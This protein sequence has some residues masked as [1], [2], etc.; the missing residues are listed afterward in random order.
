MGAD[1]CV[2]IARICACFMKKSK[3]GVDKVETEWYTTQALGRAGGAKRFEKNFFWKSWK[4][5]LTNAKRCDILIKLLPETERRRAPCKLNNEASQNSIAKEFWKKVS[6]LSKNSTGIQETRIREN[7]LSKLRK[8]KLKYIFREFD[9]GSGRTLA[10]CL[11]HASR[12]DEF[13][14]GDK[15]VADGWVTRE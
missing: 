6:T 1:L 10:A 14:S 12:T 9:P 3:K 13:P 15:L 7:L 2:K 11:T 8:N 5:Y 4:K